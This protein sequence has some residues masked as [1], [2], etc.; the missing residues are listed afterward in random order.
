M[1]KS[2]YG[3]GIEINLHIHH[4]RLLI[5]VRHNVLV[6]IPNFL[7]NMLCISA[8]ET[9]KGKDNY[10]THHVLIKLLIERSLRG[11]SPMSWVEYV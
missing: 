11:I 7:F 2:L 6:N 4:F 1:E 5:Y 9:H 10:V 3:G 8:K